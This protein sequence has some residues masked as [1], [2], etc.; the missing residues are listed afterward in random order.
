MSLPG[1]LAVS[2]GLLGAGDGPGWTIETV[3][4][5]GKAE[6]GLSEGG[7]SEVNI[8]QPF[9]VESGPDGTLY[10]C[11]VGNHRVLRLDLAARKVTT[12]AGRGEKGYSGDGGKAVEARLNE[13][14]EVRFDYDYS[15][16][17]MFVVEMAGAVVRKVDRST[18]LISTVAGAGE[19]GY[20]GDGGPAARAKLRQPHSIAL[21]GK[22]GLYVADIG[23]HR[24]RRVDL[25][26]GTIETPPGCDF[27]PPAREK[28]LAGPRALHILDGVLWI[29]FRE[30]NSV[31]RM[32]LATGRLEH[33]AGSGEKGH[34][35]GPGREARFDGPKGI[36][37]TR[38]AVYVADTEN[39]AIRAIDPRARTV[40]T[41]A[42]GARGFGGDGGPALEARLDRPHGICQGIS[43]LT[44]ETLYVGDT[45]NHRVRQLTVRRP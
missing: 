5:T 19:P 3:C 32:D 4:G 12:V 36:V 15:K 45:N 33:V 9:G 26:K 38:T 23:N 7:V 13:P 28:G 40:T 44:L 35:D 34:V 20:S 25:E 14:Y 43:I 22:G 16:G 21:D 11:E 24:I 39:H 29:A 18:G 31:W 30:G 6:L 10:I 42:G 1:A 41:V 27:T 37:A 17:A 2:L 8:G